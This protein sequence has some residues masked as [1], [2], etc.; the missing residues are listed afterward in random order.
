MFGLFKNK[1]N[2]VPNYNPEDAIDVTAQ[3]LN[4]EAEFRLKI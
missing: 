3:D 4:R 1:K 2:E